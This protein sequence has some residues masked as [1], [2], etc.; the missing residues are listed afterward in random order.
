MND[1]HELT[2][3]YTLKL[4]DVYSP[5]RL[6]RNNLA[7]WV[8][9]AL[10]CYI[11]YDFCTHSAETSSILAIVILLSIFV[12]LALLLFPV[13]RLLAL[14]R[15]TPAFARPKRITF[16]PDIILSESAEAK[17]EIKWTFFTWI[18]ETPT[19]FVFSHGKV[20]ETYIPKRCF[21]TKQ[22]IALL[23]ELIRQHFKGKTTLRRD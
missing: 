13:L 18:F 16:R 8:S 4:W 17:G 2:V 5:F 1:G 12:L 15:G 23:R 10:L 3:E 11:L 7:R 14:F 21:A 9:A 20:G 22:D 6:S 19:A